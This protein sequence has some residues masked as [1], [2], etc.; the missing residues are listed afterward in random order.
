VSRGRIGLV[1]LLAAFALVAALRWNRLCLLEPDSP[2]YLFQ[3]RSLATFDGYREIDRPGAPLHTFR[4]PGLPLLLV[5]LSWAAPFSV[6]GAKAIV[7][8]FALVALALTW[9]LAR[10]SAGEGAALVALLLVASSP[11]ALLHA[12]E[13][14]AELP[15]LAA[16]LAAILLVTRKDDP[17]ARREVAAL[18]ALLTAL[19]LLRTIGI[20]LVAAIVIWCLLDRRRRVWLGAPAVAAVATVLWTVRNSMAGG[21]SYL[22]AIGAAGRESGFAGYG[23]RCV[24]AAGFYAG[25][26]LD[27]LL[28]GVWPGRPLYERMTVGGTP[29]LG[30]LH[31]GAYVFALAACA[32][33]A[34]GIAAR[35]KREGSLI[36][37]YALAFALVLVVYPPRHE[38]LTWPMVPLA[39]ALA[40]AGVAALRR[41]WVTGAALASAAALTLW[42]AGASAAMVRDNLA[43]GAE[44]FHAERVPPLYF[45]DWQA[46]GAWLHDH[47]PRGSRVLTRHSDVGFTSGLPQESIRFEELAP[48]AWRSRIARLGARHLVVPT[49]LFGKFFPM[50]LI[51]SDPAFALEVVW[52]G[53]D[54]AVISVSPNRTGAVVP[55]PPPPP[56]LLARCDEALRGEPDRVDLQSRCA[57]LLAAAGRKDEAIERLRAIVEG[58]RADVRI[59]VVLGQLLLETRRDADAAA[60]FE[61]ASRMPEAELLSQTIARGLAAA[62]ELAAAKGIDKL[63]RA[64]TAVARARDR[65]EA[66]RWGDAQMLVEEALVFAPYDPVVVAAAGDL[67]LARQDFPA[68]IALYVQ[69]GHNG[70]AAA[71][72]KAAAVRQALETEASLDAAGPGAIAEAATVWSATG[73]PGRSMAV[74]ERGAELH[75]GD[76]AIAARLR[77]V[78]RFYGLD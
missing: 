46:A 69:A 74:L 33:A 11:Y 6:I 49:S 72:A 9:A 4:P 44:R 20:A 32:L 66:L 1:L 71:G 62:R 52:E 75:P 48:A 28:P 45:A 55:P 56:G 21:P 37:L 38:R 60:E 13:V 41:R 73:M 27:V 76:A 19:C 35:W 58:G 25:R 54:V 26:F 59:H 10:R 17:P 63:V 39:W 7:L 14:V 16:A 77:D 24:E 42:Q 2:G 40:P 23:W 5:P 36:A 3:S 34:Y 47:A 51:G 68:A 53:A 57:E 78:R 43:R 31:G 65:M 70:D 12:T 61:T 8:V 29:D 67:A 50:E 64:R 18:A 22:G 15:Y 30:G